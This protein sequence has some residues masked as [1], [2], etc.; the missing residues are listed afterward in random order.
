ME[1]VERIVELV[2]PYFSRSVL[3]GRWTRNGSRR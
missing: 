2:V 1:G 3:Q